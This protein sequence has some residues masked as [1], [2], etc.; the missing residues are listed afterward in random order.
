VSILYSASA[1]DFHVS[2]DNIEDAIAHSQRYTIGAKQYLLVELSDYA[3][4]P[5]ISDSFFRPQTAGKKASYGAVGAM[6]S[7]GA[8]VRNQIRLDGRQTPPCFLYL[9]ES[10]QTCR[11]QRTVSR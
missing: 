1:G 4:T 9:R 6:C 2:Y 11:Q 10:L 3:I 8:G 7:S 5:Q